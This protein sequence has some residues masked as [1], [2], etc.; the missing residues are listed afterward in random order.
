LLV[1]ELDW[2]IADTATNE[3]VASG[4]ISLTQVRHDPIVIEGGLMLLE[5]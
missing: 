4:I 2:E 5:N 3:D 1:N